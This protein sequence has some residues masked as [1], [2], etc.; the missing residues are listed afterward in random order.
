MTQKLRIVSWEEFGSLAER[1]ATSIA[2][3]GEEYEL[4]IGILR[5][6]GPLALMVA[7]RVRAKADFINVKSYMGMG[8]RKEP[9]VLSTIT[10]DIS[11]RKTL[12][13]DDL[14]DEGTTME[15]VVSFLRD[16]CGPKLLRTSTLFIKPWSRFKP[17]YYLDTIE[18]WVVFPWE[19]CEFNI[20]RC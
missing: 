19:L 4:V 1:L 12:V 10:E 3:S 15:F 7:D 17:D 9:R 16:N 6:G 14:V 8:S 18:E 5:G 2:R 11:G 20:L 13:V